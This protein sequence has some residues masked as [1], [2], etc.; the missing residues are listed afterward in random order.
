MVRCA[1]RAE[2]FDGVLR[3]RPRAEAEASP[4]TSFLGRA[5]AAANLGVVERSAFPPPLRKARAADDG[6]RGGGAAGISHANAAG[7]TAG[8]SVLDGAAP[9]GAAPDGTGPDGTGP[10]GTGPDGTVG[11]RSAVDG[12]A[13][14][15]AVSRRVQL[16]VAGETGADT[17]RLKVNGGE[18]PRGRSPVPV[19]GASGLGTRLGSFC[20]LPRDDPIL[21]EGKAGG[22]SATVASVT[23]LLRASFAPVSAGPPLAETSFAASITVPLADAP[24]AATPPSAAW[25]DA[26]PS[27]G[28]VL[29]GADL[30]APGLR[31]A[32]LGGAAMTPVGPVSWSS[33]RSSSPVSLEVTI[34]GEAPPEPLGPFVR[35]SKPSSL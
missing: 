12:R 33:M 11:E 27:G 21:S 30:D 23:G 18:S 34:V 1:C 19:L 32:R 35:L 2:R 13:D 4:A 20:R 14:D 25:S 28:S 9:E 22:A 7:E 10:D 6:E 29:A 16:S 8:G 24:L 26:V 31:G 17:G 15:S 5:E 3:G